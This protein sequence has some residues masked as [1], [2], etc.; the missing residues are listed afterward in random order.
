MSLELSIMYSLRVFIRTDIFLSS[1]KV[2]CLNPVL[3]AQA[4]AFGVL[5]EATYQ[6]CKSDVKRRM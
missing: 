3:P 4:A 5:I 1:F 6:Q 2:N